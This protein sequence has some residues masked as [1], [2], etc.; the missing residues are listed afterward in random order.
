MAKAKRG[1]GPVKLS[2]GVSIA[3]PT[4]TVAIVGN[5]VFLPQG[6]SSR[7]KLFGILR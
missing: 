4:E 7:E 6:I 3:R 5:S 1:S 2:E